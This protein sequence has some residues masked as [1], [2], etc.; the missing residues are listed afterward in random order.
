MKNHQYL[1]VDHFCWHSANAYLWLNSVGMTGNAQAPAFEGLSMP[2]SRKLFEGLC[3]RPFALPPS[4]SL[5]VFRSALPTFS[6][7]RSVEISLIFYA[8]ESAR[9]RVSYAV[10]IRNAMPNRSAKNG[11]VAFT[12]LFFIPMSA[13]GA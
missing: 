8:Q 3:S 6:R 9:Q 12:G 11:P 1:G 13:S 2:P 4:I 7:S 5:D 10:N